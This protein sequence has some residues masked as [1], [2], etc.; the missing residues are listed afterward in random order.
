MN[1]DDLTIQEVAEH[2]GLSAHTLRYYERIG[3]IHPIDRA[4]SGHR[5]YSPNDIGWIEFLKKLRSTGMPVREMKQYAELMWQGDETMGERRTLLETHRRR[6]QAQIDEL[7]DALDCVE[8]K[9]DHYREFEDMQRIE[10]EIEAV[11]NL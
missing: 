5:R 2:T 7:N 1:G 11:A 9:I 8:W 10:H 4:P 6:M 3:L